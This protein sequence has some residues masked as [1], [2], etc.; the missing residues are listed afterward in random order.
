MKLLRSMLRHCRQGRWKHG[1]S[2]GS[3]QWGGYA[4]RIKD[5]N[6][7]ALHPLRDLAPSALKSPFDYSALL[8]AGLHER[9]RAFSPQVHFS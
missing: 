9:R 3:S 2:W 4:E 8:S 7:L 5:I 6:Y 1:D